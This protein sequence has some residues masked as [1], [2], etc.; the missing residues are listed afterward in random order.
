MM[1]LLKMNSN[2]ILCSD[3]KKCQ[4]PSLIQDLSYLYFASRYNTPRHFNNLKCFDGLRRVGSMIVND[5]LPHG[6]WT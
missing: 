5:G 2:P 4:Q 3:V 1:P 6:L